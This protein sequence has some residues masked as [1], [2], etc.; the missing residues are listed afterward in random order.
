[1]V[2]DPDRDKSRLAV[3]EGARPATRLQVDRRALTA[4]LGCSP[5][6]VALP[7]C[8]GN[9]WTGRVAREALV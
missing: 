8:A 6:S 2:R 3:D 5:T 1:M 9:S 4:S 7:F